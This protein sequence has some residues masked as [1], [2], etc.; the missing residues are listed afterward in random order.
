MEEQVRR[1]P[2]YVQVKKQIL[3]LIDS[4]DMQPGDFIPSENRL[5]SLF[6]VSRNTVRQAIDELVNL[7]ILASH[8]GRGTYFKGYRD[9]GKTRTKLIGV[10]NHT[11]LTSIYPSIIHGIEDV[12]HQKDY[13]MVLSNSAHNTERE[14]ASLKRM[15]DIGIDGLIME[16]T[17]SAHIRP[18]DALSLLIQSLD[19]PLVFTHFSSPF[20]EISSVEID[21]FQSGYLSAQYLIQHG[22]RDIAIIIKTDALSLQQRLDGF[23]Q[24]LNDYGIDQPEEFLQVFTEKHEK[25]IP[26]RQ[27][28]RAL[29]E[30]RR[31]P[32]A[33][34]YYN[35][36]TAVQGYRYL[37]EQMISIPEDISILGFDNID[38][39]AGLHPGLTSFEHPKYHLGC[40]AARVLFDEL[41]AP[42]SCHK[43]HIKLIPELVERDS[44]RLL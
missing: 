10:I 28:T 15:L 17:F 19:I 34:Y 23:S 12:L 11:T 8:Q 1:L 5:V 32:S 9:S 41:D 31:R 4:E 43:K 14:L 2:K 27:F 16:P 24:A 7:N 36:E 21:E 18:D 40:L 20:F 6:Q 44:V 3:A 39:A 22:H 38:E 30:G 35:D 42:R 29:L 37:K 26:G 33:I 25:D 13:T